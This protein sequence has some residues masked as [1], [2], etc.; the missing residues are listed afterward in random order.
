MGSQQMKGII[1][2]NEE[3]KKKKCNCKSICV[4]RQLNKKVRHIFPS[5]IVGFFLLQE[6]IFD[7]LLRHCCIDQFFCL[8]LLNGDDNGKISENLNFYL[9]K[10]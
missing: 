9:I 1:N 5:N 10:T 8:V 2:R 3:D 7:C 4:T 6:E